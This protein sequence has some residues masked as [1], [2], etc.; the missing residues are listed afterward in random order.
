MATVSWT[1]G[2]PGSS[3][4]AWL[5]DNEAALATLTLRAEDVGRHAQAADT[6]QFYVL[7]SYSPAVWAGAS[8]LSL[9]V[10]SSAA[11]SYTLVLA[12]AGKLKQ[13]TSSSAVTVTIPANASVAFPIGTQVH[14]ERNGTGTLTLATG[15]TPTLD[16]ALSLAARARY[17]VLT[18]TKTATNRWLVSGDMA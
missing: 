9:G 8:F 10:E 6:L 12:D 1:P 3:I 11:T 14:F 4:R 13:F 16:S 17:S 15:G 2:A 7:L 18:A 5:V